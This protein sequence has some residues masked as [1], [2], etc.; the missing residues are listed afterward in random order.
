MELKNL[1]KD[2]KNKIMSLGNRADQME[3]GISDTEDRNLEM[4]Q[5]E[6]RNLRVK[7]MK[8]VYKNYL[9]PSEKAV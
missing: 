3:K 2:F 5:M 6:D 8:N 9:T 4:T 1:I 7:K